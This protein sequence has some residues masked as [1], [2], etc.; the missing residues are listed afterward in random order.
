MHIIMVRCQFWCCLSCNQAHSNAQAV[1]TDKRCPWRGRCWPEA[2]GSY[3]VADLVL[4]GFE[5]HSIVWVASMLQVFLL[6][7]LVPYSLH[8]VVEQFW[9]FI[10]WWLREQLPKLALGV[11]IRANLFTWLKHQH[12]HQIPVQLSVLYSWHHCIADSIRAVAHKD[13]CKIPGI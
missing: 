7:L 11:C 4:N 1:H 12:I 9:S 5:M 10:W 2:L 13:L 6:S 8:C 3:S